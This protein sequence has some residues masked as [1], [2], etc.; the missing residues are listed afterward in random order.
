MSN[1]NKSIEEKVSDYVNKNAVNGFLEDKCDGLP[2]HPFPGSL[3]HRSG[4]RSNDLLL[5][6]DGKAIKSRKDYLDAIDVRGTK[7]EFTILREH[8]VIYITL[9]YGADEAN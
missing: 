4:I 2:M 7:V 6:V 8:K 3:A 1:K 5:A 9:N